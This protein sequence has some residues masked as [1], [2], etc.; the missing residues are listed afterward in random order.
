[1]VG[2]GIDGQSRLLY[3]RRRAL[4]RGASHDDVVELVVG[5]NYAARAAVDSSGWDWTL[6]LAKLPF[7]EGGTRERAVVRIDG[8]HHFCIV[9]HLLGRLRVPSA[10]VRLEILNEVV[11]FVVIELDV[12]VQRGVFVQL[13]VFFSMD[14]EAELVA[15][16]ELD[17]VLVERDVA[18]LC[19]Y[20]LG[21]CASSDATR[22]P[23]KRDICGHTMLS[24]VFP[25]PAVE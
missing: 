13:N 5:E 11:V 14:V 3:E 16:V 4:R 1:M 8:E 9:G 19:V 12:V 15:V 23:R 2:P 10:F 6:V 21:E 24:S 7:G 17:I 25:S 18:D 22:W 20:L